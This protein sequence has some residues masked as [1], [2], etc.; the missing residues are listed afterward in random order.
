M[1]VIEAVGTAVPDYCL[2]QADAKKLAARLFQA[3]HLSVDRYLTVFDH[4]AID[5]RYFCVPPEWFED[6]HPFSEKNR[7]YVQAACELGVQA[8]ERC[9][10]EARRSP[11]D[12]DHLIVVSSTGLSTPSLDAHLLNRLPFRREIRR[13]PVWGLGCAG[14][15]AGLTL[16]C[17]WTRAFPHARALVLAVEFCSLTFQRQDVSKRNL[18]AASLFADGAAAVLVAGDQS[19]A[20]GPRWL[21][22]MSHTWKDSLD[23]MGWQVTDDGLEVVFSKDIPVFVRR[24]LYPVVNEFLRRNGLPGTEALRHV[25]AHPGGVKVLDA[26]AHGLQVAPAA[27]A[28]SLEVLKRYGNMS[29]PTVLFVLRDVMQSGPATGGYGLLL[30]LG[31]G[32]SAEQVLLAW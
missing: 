28:P 19:G 20:A 31:P 15:A 14:G 21:G 4:S 27:L 3:L 22:S 7:L 12:V 10:A 8:A 25:I 6:A 29:S 13:T 18:V 16:A 2:R 9:L 24:R 5:E 26:L 23:L 32:F 1:P 30:A 11:E 17:E